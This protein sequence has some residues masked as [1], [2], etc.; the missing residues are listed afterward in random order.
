[1][2]SI[3]EDINKMN[4]TKE[5]LSQLLNEDFDLKDERI[6]ISLLNVDSSYRNNEPKN[7]IDSNPR[8]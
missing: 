8:K 6:K 5:K 7:I 2:E 3:S 4:N 1:M